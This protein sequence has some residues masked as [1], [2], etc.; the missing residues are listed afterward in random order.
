VLYGHN[1]PPENNGA[2]NYLISTLTDK[3]SSIYSA[4]YK[5]HLKV[6]FQYEKCTE[7]SMAAQK[8]KF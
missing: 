8:L 1:F 5:S 2:F 3:F 7:I 4:K 6:G